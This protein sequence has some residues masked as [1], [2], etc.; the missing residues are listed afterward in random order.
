[1]LSIK[2]KK[3]ISS[4][5]HKKYR[6]KH[7][8]FILEGDKV[9]RDAL[10]QDEINLLKI[11]EVYATDEWIQSLPELPE[12]TSK[13]VHEASPEDLEAV[14][15]MVTAPGVIALARIS[16]P[17]FKTSLLKEEYTL[18]LDSIRDPGNL[19]TILRTA[20]WFGFQHVICSPDCV[21]VY[22]PKVVQASMGAI[23]RISVY[24]E[25]LADIISDFKRMRIRLFG[26]SLAGSNVF[27]AYI[28]KP[29]AIVFGN[30]SKGV[31]PEILKMVDE[32]IMIPG[33]TET[34][35]GSESLNVASSLA[36]ICAE[37]HR[38]S[39]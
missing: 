27:D 17:E 29:A 31:S 13:I 16:E 20:D 26:T 8:L 24:H 38:R 23:L 11:E 32:Q 34:H 36:I 6:E 7:G 22:N 2:R 19:G 1:M 39:Q 37:L 5:T 15:S 18:V 4:L 10:E 35:A 14:S 12:Q 28:K 33:T 25:V 3:L 21:D 9:V 30:E